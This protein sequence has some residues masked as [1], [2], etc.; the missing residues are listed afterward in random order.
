MLAFCGLG[1]RVG[2]EAVTRAEFGLGDVV[3]Q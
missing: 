3:G 2:V 1:D